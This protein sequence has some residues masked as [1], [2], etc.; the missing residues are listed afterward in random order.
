MSEVKKEAEQL[1][2]KNV[3]VKYAK[4]IKPG[5]AYDESQADLW[6]VNM[7]LT[8]EDRDALMARGINPKEDK[9]G[10][11]YWVAKRNTV[12][13]SGDPVK[14][15]QIL[16]ANLGAWS[17]D[18]IGNGSVCNIAVT[19]FPWQKSKTQKGTLLYLNAL[20]VVNHVPYSQGGTDVFDA[21][22][23]N[24]EGDVNPFG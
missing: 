20:Q 10:N 15:P 3:R 17:G 19:L 7:Y 23:G 4:V 8:D 21:V 13:K 14:A 12:N 6:S 5:K 22:E 2:L 16:A 24:T 11:E 18:D 1:V 9:E